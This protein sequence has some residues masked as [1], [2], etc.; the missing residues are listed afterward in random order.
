M[1][2]LLIC[3]LIP[4]LLYNA[5]AKT[6]HH[7]FYQLRN[8]LTA[9]CEKMKTKITSLT[10]R[11]NDKSYDIFDVGEDEVFM[12][13]TV[14]VPVYK[15]RAL[16]F[17]SDLLDVR[18]AEAWC[19]SMKLHLKMVI[20]KIRLIEACVGHGGGHHGDPNL[21]DIEGPS[22]EVNPAAAL[23]GSDAFL[24]FQTYITE[25]LGDFFSDLGNLR[26]ALD[27]LPDGFENKRTLIFK[28]AATRVT[29]LAPI[30][31]SVFT[32]IE[33]Y[34]AQKKKCMEVYLR[35][36]ADIADERPFLTKLM[37]MSTNEGMSEK[38]NPK[39][40]KLLQD[41]RSGP[42]GLHLLEDDDFAR[43]D[44]VTAGTP[45]SGADTNLFCVRHTG[46][47][48]SVQPRPPQPDP[49]FPPRMVVN[50][51]NQLPSNLVS[52]TT[53]QAPKR[54]NDGIIRNPLF[55]PG[56]VNFGASTSGASS[57]GNRPFFP[58]GPVFGT[59]TQQH[60]QPQQH[61]QP[62]QPQ[63]HQHQQQ[64]QQPEQHQNPGQNQP[65]YVTDPQTGQVY[66]NLDAQQQDP[67][68]QNNQPS[69]KKRSPILGQFGTLM[70]HPNG[71]CFGVT[72][73]NS[74]VVTQTT[75]HLSS[76]RFSNQQIPYIRPSQY[77]S[78]LVGNHFFCTVRSPS[79]TPAEK[80]GCSLNVCTDKDLPE[81]LDI[82]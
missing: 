35:S 24:Y 27:D 29:I 48:Q 9:T 12:M 26:A 69:R 82:V 14:T 16:R 60:V 20:D 71:D 30:A 22:L 80:E 10:N 34:V 7:E 58:P 15:S 72:F 52:V 17:S 51:P 5:E 73:V 74:P 33:D 47:A 67:N 18:M 53:S 75:S 31:Y 4:C 76:T 54:G 39:L 50:R 1:W 57:F 23:G 41:I 25:Q 6:F 42:Y 8:Q 36:I 77:N 19:K 28:A 55:N 63:Q 59:N 43:A 13:P 68:N 38:K 61:Q 40:R 44:Y 21:G 49:L 64:H 66:Y 78:D 46:Q 70:I 65:G 37:T 45:A 62:Q 2:R 3:V 79:K 81:D 56:G 11:A 32:N